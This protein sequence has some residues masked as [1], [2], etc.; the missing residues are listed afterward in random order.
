MALKP[1]NNRKASVKTVASI[2]KEIMPQFNPNR[3][4]TQKEKATPTDKNDTDE[5]IN[6]SHDFD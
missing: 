4:P 2:N 3:S 6:L 5:K 1:N